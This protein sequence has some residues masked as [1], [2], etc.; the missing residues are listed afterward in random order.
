MSWGFLCLLFRRENGLRGEYLALP[1]MRSRCNCSLC[2]LP[3]VCS[4]QAG[5]RGGTEGWKK[6]NSGNH[7]KM[8]A[9]RTLGR[10]ILG[11]REDQ[12]PVAQLRV[13]K[14]PGLRTWKGHAL[15]AKRGRGGGTHTLLSHRLTSPKSIN[16]DRHTFISTQHTTRTSTPRCFHRQP[17]SHMVR[18]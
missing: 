3:G 6:Q 16:L 4:A 8:Q 10:Q 11:S 15:K 13:E 2:P 17:G 12:L 1:R 14:L 9:A 5:G 18:D 7:E